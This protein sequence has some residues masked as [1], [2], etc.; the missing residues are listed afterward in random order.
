V[1]VQAPKP[2]PDPFA[3]VYFGKYHA[4]VIGNNR[5]PGFPDLK[6]A[7]PDARAVAETLRRDYGFEVDL[8]IN[9]KRYDIIG[10]LAKMRAR[11]TADDSL[12]VY[13]DG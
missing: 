2:K 3:D 9:A 5:Y 8:R 6:T 10:A 4:L 11:L 7:V 13:V 12:L 1:Q